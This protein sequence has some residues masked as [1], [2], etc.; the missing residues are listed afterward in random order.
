[1]ID[2]GYITAPTYLGKPS[3]KRTAEMLLKHFEFTNKTEQPSVDNLTNYIKNN[4][5][6]MQKQ[7]LFKIP[8][9]KKA[10]D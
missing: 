4:T 6:S 10:N 9:I 2:K 5:Y 3:H 8:S 7:S 1:M